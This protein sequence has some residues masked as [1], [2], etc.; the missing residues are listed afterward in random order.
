MPT[1]IPYFQVDSFADRPFAGNPAGVCVLPA[2]PDAA[3][4]QAIADENAVSA[5]AFLVREG[6]G[7]GLRWFTPRVEEEMCG[8]GT[9]AAAWVVLERLEPG[10][11][12][13][14]FATRAGRLTVARDGG[15]YILDLPARAIVP[16]AAP[17]GLADA[18]GIAAKEVL[19]G[20]SYIAVLEDPAAIA[21][22]RPDLARVAALDLPGVIVTAPGDGRDCDIASRY[23]APAK[24]IPEDPV[25]GS[26]HAQVV[27]FWSRRLGRPRLVARQLSRR[28]GTILCEDRGDR[29][30]LSASVAP[31]LSGTIELPD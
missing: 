13:V 3:L 25:T 15:R 2:W 17:A 30:R 19:R 21:D 31:F 7:Y 5:T 26:L 4:M 11:A 29:V 12:E 9:L 23:F 24:G 8:H 10:R 18:I 1:Q 28:G 20:A 16:C 14:S 22:L 6:D 27:P